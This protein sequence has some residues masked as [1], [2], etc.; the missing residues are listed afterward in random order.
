MTQKTN[1][2]AQDPAAQAPNPNDR[3]ATLQDVIN[4]LKD[5]TLHHDAM[6]SVLQHAVT[7]LTSLHHKIEQDEI[8]NKLEL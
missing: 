5:M 7:Y 1:D 8:S 3:E 4:T 2:L 6:R